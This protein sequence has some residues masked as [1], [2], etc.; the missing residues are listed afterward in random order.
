MTLP[1]RALIALSS[2]KA[3]LVPDSDGKP[4]HQT[5]VFIGEALHPYNVFKA[6]GIEVD[7]ASENGEWYEDS[8]SIQPGFLSDDE[9]KQYYDKEGEL[10]KK[11]DGALRARDVDASKVSRHYAVGWVG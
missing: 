10:R 6:G 2:V 8:L 9:R 5:G 1:K 7:F 11:M 3:Q 4:G